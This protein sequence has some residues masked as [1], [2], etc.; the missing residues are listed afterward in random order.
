MLPDLFNDHFCNVGLRLQE[1]LVKD[2]GHYDENAY[3]QYLPPP[4]L[5]SFF[6]MPVTHSL[7]LSEIKKLDPRKAK[8]PDNISNKVLCLCP[9]LFAHILCIIFNKA[10]T[11]GTYPSQLKLAKVIALFKKGQPFILDNYRPISLLSCFNRI[12]EKIIAYQ[13]RSI[14][15]SNNIIYDFQFGLGKFTLQLLL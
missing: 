3:K 5:N 15:E 2:H 10:V 12:F 1:K 11:A 4:T 7:I 14:C 8:G 13:L 6:L 9:D